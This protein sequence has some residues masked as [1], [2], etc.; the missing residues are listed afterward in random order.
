MSEL[1][2]QVKLSDETYRE[3]TELGKKNETYD[4]IVKRL[5]DSYKKSLKR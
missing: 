3:L 4:G 1:A 2:K 5:I